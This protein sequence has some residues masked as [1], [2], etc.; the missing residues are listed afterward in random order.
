MKVRETI[1]QLQRMLEHAGGR[2]DL[3]LDVRV[4]APGTVGGTPRVAVEILQA[5]FDWD[6]GVV[7]AIPAA[8]LTKLSPEDVAAIHESVRRG[9][10]W[11]AYQ[12]YKKQA[13]RIA[14]LSTVPDALVQFF[15]EWEQV[16]PQDAR[17]ALRPVVEQARAALKGAA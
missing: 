12:H 9:Q 8:P 15:D 17:E 1:A 10:S 4:F 16:L 3:D 11:H 5:G 13:G 14:A 2:D 7:L 6:A